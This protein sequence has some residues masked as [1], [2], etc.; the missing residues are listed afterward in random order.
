MK[1]TEI[2]IGLAIFLLM[3]LRLCFTYPYAA[4]LITLLALLLSMLYFVFGFGL[5]NQI[6]FRNLFKKESYKDISI[7][8]IIGAM[9]TGLV[10]S[11]L[12]ISIL[13]K[14]QRWPYGNIT[15]LIGLA[16]VL[17]IVIVVIFKFFTHKNRF[18]RTLLIRLSIIS[19]VGISFFFIKSETLLELKFRDFP[20]YVKA[21]KNEMKDP[22]NLELQ[23]ITDDARLKMES[24]E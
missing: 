23:K 8:R 13:F 10:L 14:F 11:I 18:Y 16:S 20:E 12:S 21:V 6:R 4:L 2:S 17:P 15:L 3:V 24:T 5:L 19:T 9:G 7:L 22:E 1:Q